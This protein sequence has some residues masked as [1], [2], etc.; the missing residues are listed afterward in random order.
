MALTFLAYHNEGVHMDAALLDRVLEKGD[1]L[2]I[3]IKQQLLADGTFVDNHLTVEEMPQQVLTDE[4]I[5]VVQIS[6]VR[7]GPLLPQGGSPQRQMGLTLAK[8]LQCLSMDVN[9]AFLLVTPEC[10]AVFRD[11]SGRYGLFDSHSR[12]PA[13]LPHPDGTAIMC[14]FTYLADMVEHLHKLFQDRGPDATYEF[15]PVVFGNVE[16]GAHSVGE[17]IITSVSPTSMAIND[18]ADLGEKQQNTTDRSEKL[19]KR[20]AQKKAYIT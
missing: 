19:K 5:Y 13:G 7:V 16:S 1:A 14:T 17:T 15:V 3:A 6:A 8:Q 9:H 12:C 20:R 2:Y 10:I 4:N 18:V 11:T